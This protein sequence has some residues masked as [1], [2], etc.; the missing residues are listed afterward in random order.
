MTMFLLTFL[1]R[2]VFLVQFILSQM[3]YR[4][5][6]F[7]SGVIDVLEVVVLICCLLLIHCVN[8]VDVVYSTCWIMTRNFNL[9]DVLYLSFT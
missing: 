2:V 1:S 8:E 5:D 6:R 9:G 4:H 7:I 3:I